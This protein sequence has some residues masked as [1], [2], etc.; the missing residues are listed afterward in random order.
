MLAYP[1]ANIGEV[2]SLFHPAIPTDLSFSFNQLRKNWVMNWVGS[3]LFC[4]FADSSW[5]FLIASG[6]ASISPRSALIY[7]PKE[8]KKQKLA[9]CYFYLK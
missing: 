8:K 9:K 2:N 4:A 1:Y 3:Q 6:L 5:S 7:P